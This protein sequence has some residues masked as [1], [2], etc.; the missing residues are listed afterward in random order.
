MDSFSVPSQSVLSFFCP[1]AYMCLSANPLIW[2]PTYRPKVRK[3][4]KDSTLHEL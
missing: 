2:M 4:T 1:F 3:E